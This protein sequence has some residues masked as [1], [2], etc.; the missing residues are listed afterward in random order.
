M[1]VAAVSRCLLVATASR[2]FILRTS[3]GPVA[4]GTRLVL[5]AS[6]LL[7]TVGP[8]PSRL[9]A[10]SIAGA[11]SAFASLL[12]I[13][14]SSPRP[15]SLPLRISLLSFGIVMV[16]P[17][18]P[19]VLE[20]PL[21]KPAVLPRPRV[22]LFQIPLRLLLRLLRSQRGVMRINLFH[23]VPQ[24]SSIRLRRAGVSPCRE[25][26]ALSARSCEGGGD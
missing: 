20:S 21:A 13:R 26:S 1:V 9:A 14:T 11:M 3:A 12:P 18:P 19:A 17:A 15:I 25:L 8:M 16:P 6:V 22:Q 10:I 4:T 24:E 2:V 7:P 5:L 23:D